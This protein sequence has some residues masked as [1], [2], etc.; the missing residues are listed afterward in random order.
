MMLTPKQ[1]LIRWVNYH[2]KR[3]GQQRQISNFTSDI[4][5]SFAYTHL[6]HQIAP[7]DAHVNTQ[8]LQV[9]HAIQLYFFVPWMSA[10][11]CDEYVCLFVCLSRR[12]S[13]RIL[14]QLRNTRDT[15]QAHPQNRK[16]ITY[17]NAARGGPTD[18]HRK[19]AQAQLELKALRECI[20]LPRWPGLGM[21]MGWGGRD[22]LHEG[23][24]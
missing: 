4:K 21:K 8:P 7:S 18:S 15:P 14:S 1:L 24:G 20:Y 11:Y 23:D 13:C 22:G 17:R 9:S 10:K 5:D 19:H 12:H 2:L 16:Y 3:A 6:L